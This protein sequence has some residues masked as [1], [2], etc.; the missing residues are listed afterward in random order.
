MMESAVLTIALG[1]SVIHPLKIYCHKMCS[2]QTCL[3]LNSFLVLHPFTAEL[4]IYVG[5]PMDNGR[6]MDFVPL[7]PGAMVIHI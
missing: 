2:L 5:W 1:I 6:S 7:R 3:S 4:Q